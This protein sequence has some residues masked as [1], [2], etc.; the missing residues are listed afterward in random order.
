LAE[1]T[2]QTA[3][4][5]LE[6]IAAGQTCGL[7]ELYRDWI[8][9]SGDILDQRTTV[10][11]VLAVLMS[12]ARPVDSGVLGG[13]LGL[14]A[15]VATSFCQSLAPGLES[16]DNDLF[17]FR[18]EDFE[19]YLDQRLTENAKRTAHG[20]LADYCMSRL[21]DGG[22]GTKHAARHLFAAQRHG[23]VIALT[24]DQTGTDA[25]TEAP[26][27]GRCAK[28]RCVL[29][30]RS[31]LREHDGTG[32]CK[33]LF[34]LVEA[35]SRHNIGSALLRDH[36]DVG[37]A[38]GK[39]ESVR[40]AYG[41]VEW[42][43]HQGNY[44]F[45]L[46]AA[47]GRHSLQEEA[48]EQLRRS[49]A[50]L[51]TEIAQA[52]AREHGESVVRISDISQFAEAA[53]WI[54]GPVSAEQVI[55]G[56]KPARARLAALRQLFQSLRLK[57]G[58]QQLVRAYEACPALSLVRAAALAGLWR[59]GLR[60]H[61]RDVKVVLDKVLSCLANHPASADALEPVLLD[62]AETCAASGVDEGQLRRLL[63]HIPRRPKSA[64]SIFSRA[65]WYDYWHDAI[66][67]AVL[68]ALISGK[69][70]SADDLL[71]AHREGQEGPE[72][73]HGSDRQQEKLKATLASLLPAYRLRA[74]AFLRG[75]HVSTVGRRLRETIEAKMQRVSDTWYRG[76]E[77]FEVL[78]D[79]AID[80]ILAARGCDQSLVEELAESVQSILRQTPLYV[81]AR[82]VER[83]C[84]D[85]RYWL[86]SED[87]IRRCRDRLAEEP[88]R[89]SEKAGLLMRLARAAL[90]RNKELSREL[91]DAA[92]Q[93]AAGL[94]D[95]TCWLLR[96]LTDIARR[97]A[98]IDDAARRRHLASDLAEAAAVCSPLAEE[99]EAM[100]WEQLNTA[101][102][103]LDCETGLVSTLK[104]HAQGLAPLPHLIGPL[105]T[106]L[107]RGGQLSP[108]LVLP[109]IELGHR[110]WAYESDAVAIL[111]RLWETG[112]RGERQ[113][114]LKL[115]DY[116][117][118]HVERDL[119]YGSRSQAACVLLDWCSAKGIRR[120]AVDRLV[121][122]RDFYARLQESERDD[123][124]PFPGSRIDATKE[125]R[126]LQKRARRS[127]R[128]FIQDLPQVVQGAGVAFGTKEVSELLTDLAF[129][130]DAAGRAQLAGK[131]TAWPS[132][133]YRF[134]PAVAEAL[135]WMLSR[136][137]GSRWAQSLALKEL[138]SYLAS[139][140]PGLLRWQEESCCPVEKLLS[141]P[142]LQRAQRGE[143]LI[144]AILDGLAELG[145]RELCNALVVL[146]RG[147]KPLEAT[148]VAEWALAQLLPPE[149]PTAEGPREA[150][151]EK[152]A[153][154]R[155]LYGL[156]AQPD[157]RL[158]WEALY[159]A[160]QMLSLEAEPL[161]RHLVE[162]S[163][164][165][166]DT[167]W[168]SARVWLLFLFHHLA[169]A[170]PKMLLDHAGRIAAHALNEDF[171][172]AGI[173]E[174]SKR[175]A[176]RLAELAPAV[177]PGDQM[178]R[179]RAVN[180]P[181]SCLWP[182]AEPLGGF[183]GKPRR[184][185]SS[186]RFHFSHM[187]TLPYWYA[188][189]GHCFGLHR[190]D[191]A[192]R[193]E[194][195]ICDKWGYTNADCMDERS[196]IPDRE[197]NWQ[198]YHNDHGSIPV[199]EELQ[200]YLEWHA[201]HMAAGEMIR[202]LPIAVG[203]EDTRTW[204]WHAWLRSNSFD[205]DPWITS[206][207]RGPAPARPYLHGVLGELDDW[208]DPAA[209]EHEKEVLSEAGWLIADAYITAHG[210]DRF[211]HVYVSSA[212]VSPETAMALARGLAAAEHPTWYGLPRWKVSYEQN[213][214][215]LEDCLAELVASPYRPEQE[216][217]IDGFLLKPWN[218]HVHSERKMHTTDSRWPGLGR[219]WAIPGQAF[220]DAVRVTRHRLESLEYAAA[221][222]GVAAK[223]EVW[224]DAYLA[225]Y[226]DDI[227]STGYRLLLKKEAILHF[228]QQ[229]AK[230]LVVKVD[231]LRS[232]KEATG[233][234]W[235]GF[236]VE[237]TRCFV[238]RRSG[239]IDRVG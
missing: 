101:V 5:A 150:D 135:A 19:T 204:G 128:K 213:V 17:L 38:L 177:L 21:R 152:E 70:L 199:M 167:L 61:C 200:T 104:W 116:I 121:E 93:N 110:H 18:D 223:V 153:L 87:I 105:V 173:Q 230:D 8:D 84:Q 53:F 149:V 33:V 151:D 201:M 227:W 157:N 215:E 154:A 141:S 55:R 203:S 40:E 147:L 97:A 34:R 148:E 164:G 178:D 47:L 13:V 81:W 42:S 123:Q 198:L 212:L 166:K 188:P 195:W 210:R 62:L 83:L 90:Q 89:A 208:L 161:L 103:Q 193:A 184:E 96:A 58:S 86:A 67:G 119:P 35:E 2:K 113:A 138:R 209:K 16:V 228:L 137:H 77:T 12:Q 59:P 54:K 100:P 65:I 197:H 239:R 238:L 189:L 115:F 179:L 216:I 27:Q 155:F 78:V 114:A 229:M 99:S 146:A 139:H 107:S 80:A 220:V 233:G 66:R 6:Q 168:M 214:D 186:W 183:G 126:R 28:E 111:D 20:R 52:R 218:V 75:R 206:D 76:D 85:E 74:D 9:A 158:R 4:A 39:H 231:V 10:E 36:P 22:Y 182:K 134:R 50:A 144:P 51:N 136:W 25:L 117:A 221:S 190:C 24:V 26:E 102:A 140:L 131:L 69:E 73:N 165:C 145:P 181:R 45:D 172:H 180:E 160:R 30:L 207:L 79:V 170:T 44:R 133:D 92:M 236:D 237:R 232:K 234:S 3:A 202:E 98:D 31:S 142:A 7:E 163:H 176:L 156:F 64:T 15:G 159:A 219:G 106:G 108:V 187:D 49:N 191:V 11:Q 63:D 162:L 72:K 171:P 130:L 124:A 82:M 175:I 120:D 132:D 95:H 56:W 205:A 112:A 91:Y 57:L 109:L 235:E 125:L 225:R 211:F 43:A 224:D 68:G 37:I 48:V 127:P 88:L 1:L 94:D 226:N 32:A 174:L 169:C 122:I 60:W 118:Q 129:R 222:H 46:A 143:V 41:A 196:S 71:P 194:R 217:E 23:G 185:W 192:A 29:G 14:A